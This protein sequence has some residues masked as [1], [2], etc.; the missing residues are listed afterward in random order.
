MFKILL[1]TLTKYCLSGKKDLIR[2]YVSTISFRSLGLNGLTQL[3]D[4]LLSDAK[5]LEYL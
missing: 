5:K 2:C 1:L 4:D 3:N